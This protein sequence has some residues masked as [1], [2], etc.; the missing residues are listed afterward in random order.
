MHRAR[1]R[2]SVRRSCHLLLVPMISS[3]LQKI[4]AAAVSRIASVTRQLLFILMELLLPTRRNYWCFC[5]WPGG[6]PHTL[7]NPRAVFEEVKNDPTI[8]KVILLRRN[9]PS[10][11][12]S[13]RGGTNVIFVNAESVK[14]AYF[15][16]VSHTII[17]G[18]ALKAMAS[19]SGWV[20][21]KHKIVQ[22]SHGIALKRICR[23]FPEERF[24]KKETFKYTAAISSSPSDQAIFAAA[25]DPV[26]KDN[27][28]ITG[29]PR[30]DTILR[31][32]EMLPTDY[33]KQLGDLRMLMAG[34][35]L[36]LYAPTW[37]QEKTGMYVFSEADRDRLRAVMAKHNAAFA[38]RAHANRRPDPDFTEA[39][40]SDDSILDLNSLPEV[41]LALRVADVLVT[42]FS[43][44]YQDFL[45]TGK[46]IIHF[47]Y[48]LAEYTAERGFLYSLDD[49]LTSAPVT[50]FDE[51]LSTLDHALSN[52][53]EPLDKNRY[54]RAKR[55][56]HAH[57]PNPS[58]E[59]AN[60]IRKLSGAL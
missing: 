46:P 25:Y 52:G 21:R 33:R 26:G 1:T 13:A 28:W 31:A 48:D 12:S 35:R 38:I 56:F 50:S 59:V 18:F 14:G 54:E 41:N 22:L 45:L 34:R 36:V 17:L 32:E 60:R 5:A 24:W 44:I 30:N 7:D 37:R 9:E 57:G 8:V 53:S 6:Y 58:L 3:R 4:P 27:V 40:A 49:A 20:T 2:I 23:L 43:S 15:L 10:P 11:T 19:Y 39:R 47:I 16:A 55:L 42:D 29:L 51:L